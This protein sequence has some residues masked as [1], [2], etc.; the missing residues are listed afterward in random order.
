MLNFIS[1][2]L[3]KITSLIISS[4]RFNNSGN[5]LIIDSSF[6]IPPFIRTLFDFSMSDCGIPSPLTSSNAAGKFNDAKH[7]LKNYKSVF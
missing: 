4:F 1:I 7:L 2:L 3:L 5:S 6:E